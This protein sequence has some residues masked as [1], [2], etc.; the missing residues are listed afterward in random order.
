MLV[1]QH[2]VLTGVCYLKKNFVSRI[3]WSCAWN[4]AIVKTGRMGR[5]CYCVGRRSHLW[6]LQQFQI[7]RWFF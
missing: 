2:M 6:G 5:N 7:F 1:V 3:R 4:S